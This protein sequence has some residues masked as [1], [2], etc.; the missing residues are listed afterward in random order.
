MHDPT[1]VLY[2]LFMF[3]CAVLALVGYDGGGGGHRARLRA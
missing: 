3:L 1:D 2:V